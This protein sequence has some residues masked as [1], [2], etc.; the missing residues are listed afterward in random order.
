MELRLFGQTTDDVVPAQQAGLTGTVS[1]HSASQGRD[2]P[3]DDSITGYKVLRRN[4]GVGAKESGNESDELASGE[5]SDQ[6][7][8][9]RPYLHGDSGR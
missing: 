2:D 1:P 3:G 8:P 7:S 5:R 6:T 4:P 9:A